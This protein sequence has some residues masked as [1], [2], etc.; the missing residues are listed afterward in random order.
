MDD[1]KR[2][3]PSRPWLDNYPPGVDFFAKIDATPVFERVAQACAKYPDAVALDFLGAEMRYSELGS[4]IDFF[5]GA[6]QKE[7]GVKK[8]AR[9]ALLLPN[10][11][12]FAIAYYGALRAG[13]TV[14][15]CNPL[16]TVNEL[17]HILKNSGA[18]IIVTLDLKALFEKAEA[19]SERGLAKKIIVCSFLSALPGLKAMLFR[20]AKGK[21]LAHPGRS[22]VADRVV[23]F[24]GLI[25]KGHAPQA[26]KIDPAKDVAVQQYTGGTTGVPKGALLSHANVSANLSQIDHYGIGLFNHPAKTVAV[27]PFFHIFAMTVCLNAPLANGGQVVMLPRFDLK[28]L[29]ALIKRKQP[30]ILPAVPTLL[31]TIA[32][33]PLTQRHDLN[34]LEVCISG[35]AALPDETRAAFAKISKGLLAE[36]Y[37]LTE[38]SPVVCCAGLRSPSRPLS[39]GMPL[40]GTDIRFVSLE[41]PTQEVP[42]GERGEL[43]VKGP[44]VMLGYYENTEA[45][46]AAFA[47][48]WLRTGDV[49]HFDKDGFAYLVDRIKDLIIVNGFNVY[50]RTI[51]EALVKHPAVDECTVIGVKDKK[52]GEA[53]MAFVKLGEGKTVSEAELKEFLK[54]DLSPLEMPREIVFRDQL[55]KTLIGKL[56]KKELKAEMDA[57][58]HEQA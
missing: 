10:I 19:L 41:D 22:K 20:I 46:K 5:C 37:G 35:G 2:S 7:L 53:P 51:E 40:P 21:D 33:S 16:Y 27:L 26:V 48:G 52:K 44:Q 49:G 6:L 8:G 34:S 28:G 43:V 30:K 31:Q 39:I 42:L 12:Y 45:T 15:N 23:A 24:A 32:T 57:R 47:D 4:K 29:L 56:S 9:I 11:P 54:A 17:A 1:S 3:G 36:G 50:P 55:P 25:E 13:A 18:E 14:V 58:E 38:A